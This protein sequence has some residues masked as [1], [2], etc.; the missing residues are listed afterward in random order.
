MRIAFTGKTNKNY[1]AINT[2]TFSLK[3]GG[4]L[5]VDRTETD[6]TIANGVLSMEWRGCYIWE[7][8]GVCTEE[9]LRLDDDVFTELLQGAKIVNVDIEDD[10]EKDYTVKISPCFGK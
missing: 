5:T 10:V 8:N 2:I 4:T 1:V 6:Y 7:I 3:K 9:E